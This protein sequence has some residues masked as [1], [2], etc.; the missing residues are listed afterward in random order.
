[1][2]R[3]GSGAAPAWDALEAAAAAGADWSPDDGSPRFCASVPDDYRP[4]PGIPRNLAHFLD[5]A[6]IIA[7]D[8]ALQAI[9]HAGLGAGAGDAR[10]F[11]VVD[12]LPYRAPGQPALFAP[13]G[14]LVARALGVRGSVSIVGGHEAGALSAV[15]TATRLLA[16]GA[17]DV[18]IAGGA[19][20]LQRPLLDHVFEQNFASDA[21]ARPFDAAH[22]G[23][24]VA[25]GAAYMVVEREAHARERGARPLAHIAG[26]GELFDSAVEPLELSGAPEA[27]RAMQEALAHAGYVQNQVD[28]VVS[29]ADGRPLSDFAEGYGLQRTFGRHAYFAGVT[30]V[31]GALGFSLGASGGVSLVA[32]LEAM[33]R[34]RS[35]P[36]AGFET[37]EKDVE[38]NYV[39][40]AKDERLDT[41]LVT[42]LGLG[43]TDVSLLLERVRG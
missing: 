32:A 7:L 10:R 25:E 9:E 28:L 29:C 14:H 3:C 30:T 34:Q 19:Q 43:G 12:G 24:V 13:Y 23:Y 42:S 22:K 40:A 26:I 18:V 2:T 5:R 38:L 37:A 8:A 21:P 33:Q 27:G 1:V 35:F 4:N 15:A 20:G 11:A 17:A 39:R 31:A 6:A 41:V 36:V 16:S